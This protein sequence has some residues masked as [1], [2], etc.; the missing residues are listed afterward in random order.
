[1]T[2]CEG[3]GQEGPA[4]SAGELLLRNAYG[5]VGDSDACAR[6]NCSVSGTE[7]KNVTDE[8][9]KNGERERLTAVGGLAALSLDALSSVAYGPEAILVVLVTAGAGALKYMAAVRRIGVHKRCNAQN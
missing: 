3:C 2:E 9:D 1:M 4:A 7:A 6:N 5:R 8:A